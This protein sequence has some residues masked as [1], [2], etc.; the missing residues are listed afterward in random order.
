MAQ[1]QGEEKLA[2]SLRVTVLGSCPQ[3]PGPALTE[4]AVDDSKAAAKGTNQGRVPGQDCPGVARH[5]SGLE[6]LG[7]VD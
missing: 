3:N 1:E 2:S 7:V 6:A 4:A 5:I